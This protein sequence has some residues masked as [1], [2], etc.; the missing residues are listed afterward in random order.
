MRPIRLSVNAFGPFAGTETINFETTLDIGLFGIYGP[1]GAGKTSIFDALCF[2]LFGQSAGAQREGKDFRSDHAAI[3]HLTEVEF[4]FDLGEKRYVIH[5]IPAQ[6]RIA[7]R[8]GKTT[9]QAHQ[10][11]L[12]DAT[13]M[14]AAQISIENRGKPIAEKKTSIVEKTISDLLGYSAEQFR[15]IILLPQ[16][17][18]RKVLDANTKDRSQIL[19]QL[20]DVSLYERL[21]DK[22]KEQASV[23]RDKVKTASIQ[24]DDRLAQTGHETYEALELAIKDAEKTTKT[25]QSEFEKAKK[26]QTAKRTQ[27]EKAKATNERFVDLEKAS[28]DQAELSAKQT[29]INAQKADLETAKRAESLIGLEASLSRVKRDHKEALDRLNASHNLLEQTKN[30]SN[31]ALEKLQAHQKNQSDIDRLMQDQTK[32]ESLLEIH[33]STAQLEA[34]L[35]TKTELRKVS[36]TLANTAKQEETRLKAELKDLSVKASEAV[37]RGKTISNL[38]LEINRLED[39]AKSNKRHETAIEE[40]RELETSFK[41]K[42]TQYDTAKSAL[43]EAKTTFQSAE[44]AL[45][46]V[47]ALHLASKLKH[48]DDCPVCGSKDH[49]QLAKG[50]ASSQGLD[51]A[52]RI[53]E[54]AFKTAEKSERKAND[55]LIAEQSK[56]KSAQ[57]QLSKLE[58]PELE[59]DTLRTKL[60]DQQ[61]KL[62]K[63]NALPSHAEIMEKIAK[64]GEQE[65]KISDKLEKAI[66]EHQANQSNHAAAQARYDDA[67]AKLPEEYRTRGKLEQEILLNKNKIETYKK[68][69]DA[70]LKLER[71]A[72]AAFSNAQTSLVDKQEAEQRSLKRAN[73]ESANFQ[74]ALSQAKLDQESFNQAKLLLP[75]RDAI[76]QTIEK[77]NAAIMAT[78][79][80]VEQALLATSKLEQQDLE[81]LNQ[82]VAIAETEL[83]Q[84]NTN[85]SEATQHLKSLNTTLESVKK[86][87]SELNKLNAEYAP[88]GEMA[89]LTNGTNPYKLKLVDFAIAAM[90]DDV[91]DAANQRLG[92]MTDN[93]FELRREAGAKGGNASRGLDTLIFDAHTESL[94]PTTSLSGGEGFLASLAL[95]LGLSDVVQQQSGGVRL[96]AIFI[97]EGFGSLDSAALDLALQTLQNLANNNRLVG[98]ISHVDEVKRTIPNGFS[99]EPSPAG[100]HIKI[101]NSTH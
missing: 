99:I 9:Q 67:I 80:R 17:Q 18:F 35:Q 59:A 13:G 60:A 49:P 32:L 79:T 44:N 45:A 12:F 42:Q 65:N 90:Y 58:K 50:D 15:Q 87:T 6:E 1:T 43:S 62:K 96:D 5:R 39:I 57:E 36:H 71:D 37:E 68:H 84:A 63:L 31:Q 47:Q 100:S 2:A 24:R 66:S 64:L 29:S 81:A 25:A 23:L 19:R 21:Q 33:K 101:R 85:A 76:L 27:L 98:I 54:D 94:R 28:A 53:A 74:T 77:H 34:D 14:D 70:L 91:L 10:A 97:D 26:N 93:R 30:S 89:D 86:A 51:Q 46:N 56:F 11:W 82:N 48:G 8:G 92:P 20:F 52:F 69:L 61:N 73:S 40:T 95:A 4:V 7:K 75:K 78:Q 72:S 3:D 38:K 88:L 22:L 16:G 41:A 83:E 55:L